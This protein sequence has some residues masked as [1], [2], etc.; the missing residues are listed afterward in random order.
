MPDGR[1]QQ[2]YQGGASALQNGSHAELEFLPSGLSYRIDGVLQTPTLNT[3]N[4]IDSLSS[5]PCAALVAEVKVSI[6]VKDSDVTPG[7]VPRI[8]NYLYG[9]AWTTHA[10]G[11]SNLM[12]TAIT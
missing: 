12:I 6:A 2:W 1:F 9:G 7:G 11:R 5:G 8:S 3:G 4:P 10:S